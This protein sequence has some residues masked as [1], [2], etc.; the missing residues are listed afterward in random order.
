MCFR[1]WSTSR[2]SR[3]DS[4][5]QAALS[6]VGSSKA[7]P[8]RSYGRSPSTCCKQPTL[9]PWFGWTKTFGRRVTVQ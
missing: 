8:S 5:S 4:I 1:T 3:H 2:F 7:F 6:E 9:A